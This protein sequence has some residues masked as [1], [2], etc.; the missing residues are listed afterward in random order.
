MYLAMLVLTPSRRTL[1]DRVS[2]TAVTT[3]MGS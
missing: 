1:Y 2:G 3:A